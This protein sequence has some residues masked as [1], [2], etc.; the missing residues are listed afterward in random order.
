MLETNIDDM[1][2]ELYSYLV[3]QLLA[4]GARDVFLTNIVMKK[5]R[6]GVLLSVL[7]D[8]QDQGVLE[9]LLFRETTTFGIR[10][11]SVERTA[12]NRRIERIPTPWGDIAVK[13]GMLDGAV[14]KIAPEYEDCRAAAQYAGLSL[15]EV[16]QRVMSMARDQ[17]LC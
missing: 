8:E 12:L 13:V 5:G 10:R 4:E 11:R 15:Q 6:P 14:V 16:Y 1:N 2:P 17:I 3:P 9:T 7:C